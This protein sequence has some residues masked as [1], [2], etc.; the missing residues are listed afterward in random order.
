MAPE[1]HR[2][3]EPEPAAWL[4]AGAAFQAA[5]R[6]GRPPVPGAWPA[7]L[8]GLATT[9]PLDPA[10][11]WEGSRLLLA[12]LPGQL[13]AAHLRPARQVTFLGDLVQL[14]AGLRRRGAGALALGDRGALLAQ[15]GAG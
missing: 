9:A 12:Q 6:S 4:V 13:V 2:G 11:P 14:R 7:V 10:L 1:Q 8:A 5:V 15:R 3:P